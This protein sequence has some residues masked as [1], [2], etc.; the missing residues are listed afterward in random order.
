MFDLD[1]G[2]HFDEVEFAVFVEEF[3]GARAVVADAFA[4]FDA[5]GA[6]GVALF[7]AD[8]GGGRFF[9]DF[10]VAALERAVAFAEVDGVAVFVGQYLDFDV[11]RGFE[12]FFHVHHVV[13]KGLAR[14]GF[15]EAYGIDDFVSAAHDAHATTAAAASGFDDDGI[16]DALGGG[17]DFVRICRQRA[18]GAGNAGDARGFHGFD[19]FDFVAHHADGFGARAD[20][21]EAGLFDALGEV[22]VFGE[23]AVAGVD[24][25]GVGDFGGGDDGRHIEVA[26]G[27][28]RGTDA[29]GFVGQHDVFEVG[30]GLGV[31]GDGFDAHFAAGAQDAQRDFAAVGDQHFLEHGALLI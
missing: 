27:R 12:E 10:L 23:E 29:D 25:V 3:E 8:A 1:A 13:A 6:D 28:W 17:A 21:G 19:G 24:G 5:D 11:A 30:I 4:G 9:H 22:G 16:A 18:V 15:G 20:E 7:F 31:D 14:F 26:F 2:V